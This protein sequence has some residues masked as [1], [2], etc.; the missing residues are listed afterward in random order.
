MLGNREG[1]YPMSTPP[2]KLI[3]LRCWLLVLHIWSSKSCERKGG[4]EDFLEEVEF[5]LALKVWKNCDSR[6]L[7]MRER[8]PGNSSFVNK[9]I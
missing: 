9:G 7:G 3:V 1:I 2:G 4:A 5:E 8:H 6:R